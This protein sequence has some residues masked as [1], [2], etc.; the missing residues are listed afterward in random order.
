MNDLWSKRELDRHDVLLARLLSERRRIPFSCRSQFHSTFHDSNRARARY[1][2]QQS[3]IA[4]LHMAAIGLS[5][6]RN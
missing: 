6:F 5:P 2:A 4:D 3:H 1:S